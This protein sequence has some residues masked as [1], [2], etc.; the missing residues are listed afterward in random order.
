MWGEGTCDKS[1]GDNEEH[2]RHCIHLRPR[3]GD[4]VCCFCGDLFEGFDIARGPHGQYR[5]RG[6]RRR[7]G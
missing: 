3:T 4:F 2:P 1:R 5:P 6:E 7:D